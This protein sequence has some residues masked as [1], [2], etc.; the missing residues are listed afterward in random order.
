MNFQTLLKPKEESKVKE[1]VYAEETPTVTLP[2]TKLEMLFK[3][4]VDYEFQNQ[5]IKLLEA[6]RKKRKPLL[7]SQVK[8]SGVIDEK[9]HQHLS[10]KGVEI[11][12]QN[13]SSVKF[14]SVVA[15][16]ILKKKKLLD[17]CIVTE[18][19]VSLD[20]GKILEAY[21]GGLLTAKDVDQMFVASNSTALL[22]N[23]DEE[24]FPEYKI[25]VALR[26]KMEKE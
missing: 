21:N 16:Q 23:L 5:Q 2:K 8:K 24:E 17:S 4:A 25:L 9:G 26:K 3:T 19:V 22:V 12:L 10:D 13:R 15:E 6:K 18:T 14:N 11:I 20:E 7:E 1:V